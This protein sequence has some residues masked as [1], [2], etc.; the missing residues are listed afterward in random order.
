MRNG[1]QYGTDSPAIRSGIEMRLHQKLLLL[2]FEKQ[3][4][5]RKDLI[6]NTDTMPVTYFLNLIIYDALTE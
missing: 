2:L 3:L 4:S 1:K 5:Q 6:V